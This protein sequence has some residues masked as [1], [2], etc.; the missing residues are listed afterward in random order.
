MNVKSS[1]FVA[2]A[3]S[4]V[5]GATACDS[6]STPQA[7][8]TPIP[9][10][11]PT[12]P[13]AITS[14]PA[15]AQPGDAGQPANPPTAQP[16]P[17]EFTNAPPPA[18]VPVDQKEPAPAPPPAA[19][20]GPYGSGHGLCFDLNS[21]L[22]RSAVA[23]LAPNKE[24]YPWV[25]EEA[26]TDPISAG[27]DGVLSWMLVDWKGS[28]P[29]YHVLFFTNGTYLGTATSKPYGY[30]TVHDQSTKNRVALEY[31]WVTPQDALCCPSGGPN[32]VTFTLNGTTVQAEG[33]FPPDN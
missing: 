6:S 21:E 28:H 5:F 11:V 19:G 4:V 23:R 9:S 12:S 32:W 2:L 31:R 14:A 13:S 7:T 1:A 30:T 8:R 10:A 3:A 24:G 20:Q 25:I 33:Q 27:C 16:N 26:S 29:A 17:P 15:P 22:A 18:S